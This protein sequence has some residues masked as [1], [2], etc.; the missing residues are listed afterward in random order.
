MDTPSAERLKINS[1]SKDQKEFYGVCCEILKISGL[2][3]KLE[4]KDLPWKRHCG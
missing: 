3:A 4:E 2:R 1:L